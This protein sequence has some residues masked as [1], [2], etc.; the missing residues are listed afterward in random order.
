MLAVCDKL[1]NEV[2]ISVKFNRSAHTKNKLLTN[3]RKGWQNM[4]W[5]FTKNYKNAFKACQKHEWKDKNQDRLRGPLTQIK[6]RNI[7]FFLF[8]FISKKESS[9]FCFTI[10]TTWEIV[11]NDHYNSKHLV[12]KKRVFNFRETT[13]FLLC[14]LIHRFLFCNYMENSIHNDLNTWYS[15]DL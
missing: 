9:L 8:V 13:F 11:A 1:C 15:C 5:F 6:K 14:S 7:S 4:T 12:R 10:N 2:E 3:S